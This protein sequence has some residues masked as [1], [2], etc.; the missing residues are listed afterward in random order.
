MKIGERLLESAFG[1]G[2][3]ELLGRV[4]FAK[5]DASFKEVADSFPRRFIIF[6]RVLTPDFSFLTI[7]LA[8]SVCE[9]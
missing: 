5:E 6:N 8:V 2:F 4:L 7:S 3:W 9:C 1:P